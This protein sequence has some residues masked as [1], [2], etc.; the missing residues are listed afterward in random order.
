MSDAG[1]SDPPPP[2]NDNTNTAEYRDGLKLAKPPQFDG[3]WAN[4]K[5]FLFAITLYLQATAP[6]A[7]DARKIL[8]TL[9]Y[10]TSGLALNWKNQYME[11]A[12]KGKAAETWERFLKDL[13]KTF[14]D[15][16]A[17]ATA[18]SKLGKYC[19]NKDQ[20]AD[21]FFVEFERLVIDAGYDTE[22]DDHLVELLQ[23]N[24]HDAIIT[25]IWN[26]GE[27]PNDYDGWKERIIRID[28]AYRQRQA[29][30]RNRWGTK[31]WSPTNTNT[32][33]NNN[34][35]KGGQKHSV[36]K[37]DKP[38]VD[39]AAKSYGYT[40]QPNE[41]MRTDRRKGKGPAGKNCFKCGEEGHFAR[42]CH[43]DANTGRT[44]ELK[45]TNDE[46]EKLQQQIR[47]LQ[48]GLKGAEEKD[49][50]SEQDFD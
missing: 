41:P 22:R 2:R 3:S 27:V 44:R 17:E 42:D 37:K 9:S 29:R 46:I 47:R 28:S 30:R 6:Q 24:V 7:N 32:N 13:G 12:T 5:S 36:D 18:R 1:T 39:E 15:T 26:S 45:E 19:Q 50:E 11:K 34:N 21:E 43:A 49:C 38:R 4:F 8:F 25:Q 48:Q 16:H 20:S 10:M 40:G 35:N 33:N 14:T 23:D 31:T